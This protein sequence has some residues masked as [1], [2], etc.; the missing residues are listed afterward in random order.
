MKNWTMFFV[1]D[2]MCRKINVHNCFSQFVQ[3]VTVWNTRT[4]KFTIFLIR[5]SLCAFKY[6]RVLVSVEVPMLGDPILR[7][8]PFQQLDQDPVHPDTWCTLKILLLPIWD[9][10]PKVTR[11]WL[12]RTVKEILHGKVFYR[13]FLNTMYNFINI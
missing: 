10:L 1:S 12:K 11:L 7:I 2:F 9:T 6:H 3:K 8:D 5:L 13:F 4:S